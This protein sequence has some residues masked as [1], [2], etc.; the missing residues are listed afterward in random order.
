MEPGPARQALPGLTPEGPDVPLSL[1][2]AHKRSMARGFARPEDRRGLV[3]AA[4]TLLPLAG[5][6]YAAA[7]VQS[8]TLL[9]LL[10]LAIAMFVLRVFALMHDCGHGSLFRS[11]KLNR[12][13]GFLFGVVCGMPQYVWAHHHQRHHATNG[14]WARYRG[15]LAILSVNE[16]DLLTP[17]QRRAYARVRNPGLAP[18]AGLVYLVVNPRVT[19]LLGSAALVRHAIR[20]QLAYPRDPAGALATFRTRHWASATEYR[21]MTLN[22]LAVF[23]A[24]LAMSAWIGPGRFFAI[25]LASSA[26]AGAAGLA[27]FT[28]QHNFEHSYASGDDGWD[29]DRAALS[30]TSFLVLPAWLNWFT[31]DIGYHHVHHLCAHIPNYRLAAC[32]AEHR[33]LFAAVPRLRLADVGRSLQ[34]ILWSPVE[35]R[36]VTVAEH[37]T[38]VACLGGMAGPRASTVIL[39]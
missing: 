24:W 36:L 6:W 20:R 21:H 25:Y 28:V 1:D 35:G 11:R 38:A 23:G 39:P 18:L 10:T 30:G 7:V 27:L 31:A 22:N 14:N 34:F 5:L 16:Y 13:F 19:W 3:Q 9:A 29:P 32:H 26:I 2:R 15:P 4:T 8:A 33:D 17:A 12:G 37:E